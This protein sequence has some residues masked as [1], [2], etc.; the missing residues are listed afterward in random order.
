MISITS[1]DAH[2]IR[3]AGEYMADVAEDQTRDYDAEDRESIR[4]M[5]NI[6]RGL[7][8]TGDAQTEAEAAELLK[9][10]VLVELASWV[11]DASQRLIDRAAAALGHRDGP[12]LD[13]AAADCGR[14]ASVHALTQD[15]VCGIFVLRCVHCAHLYKI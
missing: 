6:S 13:A 12:L 3:V 4:R 5:S 9:A 11:P 14:E 8:V 15:W 1:N 7:L 10:V 2:M